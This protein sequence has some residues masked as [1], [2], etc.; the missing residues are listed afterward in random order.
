MATAALL[1]PRATSRT[2]A[3]RKIS[4]QPARGKKNR[5]R[6]IKSAQA[7]RRGLCIDFLGLHLLTL[8]QYVL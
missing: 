1:E 2:T 5:E 7:A 8:C 4:Q 6:F 3:H